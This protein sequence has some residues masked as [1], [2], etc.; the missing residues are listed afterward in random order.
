[1]MRTAWWWWVGLTMWLIHTNMISIKIT[2]FL[3]LMWVQT[4]KLTHINLIFLGWV[5]L[6][7]THRI[8]QPDLG[9]DELSW[10]QLTSFRRVHDNSL[11]SSYETMKWT[12]LLKN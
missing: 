8:T 7:K 12:R 11:N 5:E 1:L 3:A 2:T 4:Q 10:V 6:L 9:Y